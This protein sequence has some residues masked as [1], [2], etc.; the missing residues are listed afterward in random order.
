MDIEEIKDFIRN[1]VVIDTDNVQ[2]YTAGNDMIV[3]LRFA[4]EADFFTEATI[5]IPDLD[6]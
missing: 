2:K 6:D 4:D 1:N 5:Y 3:G